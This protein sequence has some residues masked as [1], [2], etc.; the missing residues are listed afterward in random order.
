VDIQVNN[1]WVAIRN[2]RERLWE[3][4]VEWVPRLRALMYAVR[5]RQDIVEIQLRRVTDEMFAVLSGEGRSEATA[6][7]P[8]VPGEGMREVQPGGGPGHGVPGESGS[9]DPVATESAGDSG[10]GEECPKGGQHQ[11][12]DFIP[13]WDGAGSR[14]ICVKCDQVTFGY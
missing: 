5:R 14:K 12:L 8:G 2:L 6:N 13:E 3:V 9:D 11:W 1:T 10:P 7:T 4:E